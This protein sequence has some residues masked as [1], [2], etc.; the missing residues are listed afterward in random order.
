MKFRLINQTGLEELI[1]STPTGPERNAL[2]DFNIMAQTIGKEVSSVFIPTAVTDEIVNSLN[3]SDYYYVITSGGYKE[4]WKGF[5]IKRN[6]T[7]IHSIL[8]EQQ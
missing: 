8:I 5:N 1:N 6:P 7:R 2:C 4:T 3:D